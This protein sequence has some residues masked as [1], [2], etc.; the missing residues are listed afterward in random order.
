MIEM[1]YKFVTVSSD[2]RSMSTHAQ[3]IVN[4]MKNNEKG[5]LSSSSY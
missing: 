1:G 5:K 3:N 2:F 4:K